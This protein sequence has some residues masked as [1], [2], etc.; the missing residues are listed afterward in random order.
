M[1]TS[2]D[3]EAG[4]GEGVCP[5]DHHDPSLTGDMVYEVYDRLRAQGVCWSPDNGGVWMVSE[6]EL[7]REVLKDHATYCSSEGVFVPDPGRRNIV[8]EQDPPEHETFRKLFTIAVG[9]PAVLEHEPAIR[10]MV[11]RVVGEFAAAGGGDA[12]EQIGEKVPVEAVALM[13]GLSPASASR[14]RELTNE[15]WKHLHEGEA[16]VAPLI[17]ML[18]SEVQDRRANPRE[19][20]LTTLGRAQ[21]DGRAVTDE[22]IG[23]L[24]FGAVVAGHET[25]MNASTNLMLELARDPA[26]QQRLRE[27]PEL[28]PEVV[29]ECLRHRA[30]I[31]VFF[32]TVTRDTELGGRSLQAGDKVGVLYAAANRDPARFSEPDCFQPDR[33]DNAHLSFGWGIHRCVGSFLAQTEL[34]LL[35]D[36]LLRH[37]TLEL[38][39]APE[40][41][42]L[43]AHHMGFLHLPLRIVAPG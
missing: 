4:T 40:P 42:P 10:Q 14:V 8:L 41:K 22:E 27:Q 31:H 34:R 36:A 17:T 30:P 32:R 2:Y 38:D 15:A 11:E 26:L 5:F 43:Q 37:G 1:E 33:K 7:A 16:A 24:L 28:I 29:E 3:R 19:D 35:T 25:T 9:R 13:Y 18:L 21:V 23:N 20:F 12:R 39:G 6:Y